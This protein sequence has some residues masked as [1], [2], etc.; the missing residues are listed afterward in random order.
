MVDENSK[1]TET[2]SVAEGIHR[3]ILKYPGQRR[4]SLAILQDVQ[5]EFKYIPEEAIPLIKRHVGVS[6][7]QLYALATFYKALSLTPKGQHI[8]KLCDGTA[9]HLRGTN[10][11]LGELGR[12]LGIAADERTVDGKF[13][14]ELVNCVGSCALAPVM[15]VDDDYHGKV[16]MGQ[17]PQVIEEYR[18][19]QEGGS[20][21]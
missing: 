20:D 4:Y 8:I 12:T 5:K 10:N 11:L 9:C 16:T 2:G 7:G 18:D 6:E 17:L 1:A 21:E 15:I 3:I 13:S 19:E 14:L